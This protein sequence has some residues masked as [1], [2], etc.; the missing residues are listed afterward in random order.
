MLARYPPEFFGCC[1]AFLL[2]TRVASASVHPRARAGKACGECGSVQVPCATIAVRLTVIEYPTCV[3]QSA[4]GTHLAT[5]E[6][7]K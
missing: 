1:A 2:M 7:A 4:C 6:A 5:A 3:A